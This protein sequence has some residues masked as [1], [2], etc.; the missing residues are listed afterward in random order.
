MQIAEPHHAPQPL[1][2]VI[3]SARAAAQGWNLTADDTIFINGSRVEGFENQYSDVDREHKGLTTLIS[4]RMETRTD[5]A[6][7]K[8]LMVWAAETRRF[9][10]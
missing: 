5:D 8:Q 3:E 6:R 1:E 4:D 7:T 2:Q 9:L 10:G